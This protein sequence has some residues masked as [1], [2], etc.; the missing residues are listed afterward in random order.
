MPTAAR[1]A[2]PPSQLTRAS[3]KSISLRSVG[4]LLPRDAKDL[5]H[6]TLDLLVLRALAT[7]PMHGFE[8][9]KWIDERTSGE[10]GIVDSV[11]YVTVVFEGG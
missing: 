9:S 6:G 1:A 10:L 4:G 2:L 8:L 5:L 7:E 11:L 3:H